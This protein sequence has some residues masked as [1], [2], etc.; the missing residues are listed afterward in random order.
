MHT[1]NLKQYALGHM[2]APG[3]VNGGKLVPISKVQYA[4]PPSTTE[5]DLIC[6]GAKVQEDGYMGVVTHNAGRESMSEALYNTDSD[7]TVY[8]YHVH[9]LAGVDRY[10]YYLVD[11]NG[12]STLVTKNHS[13]YINIEA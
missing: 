11:R 8:R 1:R 2:D 4:L 7:L 12:C 13:H 9:N 6:M 3:K 5:L 10:A